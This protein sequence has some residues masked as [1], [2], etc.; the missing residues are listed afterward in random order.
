MENPKSNLQT[1]IV[2]PMAADQF[3]TLCGAGVGGNLRFLLSLFF[4]YICVCARALAMD[5]N[6][7]FFS[8][9][10]HLPSPSPPTLSELYKCDGGFG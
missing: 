9:I 4:L 5:S 10:L 6:P 2:P 3:P 7:I 8:H 1:E